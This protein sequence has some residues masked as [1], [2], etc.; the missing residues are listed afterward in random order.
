LPDKSSFF[1]AFKSE[2]NFMSS[3]IFISIL[4]YYLSWVLDRFTFRDFIGF[5]SLFSWS[6]FFIAIF[7]IIFFLFAFLFLHFFFTFLVIH[8]IIEIFLH[9]D[10]FYLIFIKDLKI[11]E[12]GAIL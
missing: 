11:F 5:G 9:F 2:K 1:V 6:F 7:L 8:I 4:L 12:S 10:N 3:F